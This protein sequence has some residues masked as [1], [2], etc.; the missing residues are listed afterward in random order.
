M[1]GSVAVLF[2][3]VVSVGV[4]ISFFFWGGGGVIFVFW[5]PVLLCVAYCVSTGSVV[6][7][8][9]ISREGQFLWFFLFWGCFLG[10]RG[11]GGIFVF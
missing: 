3:F 7:R 2:C 6:P 9:E 8:K 1:F 11:G 4:F 10:G 5:L